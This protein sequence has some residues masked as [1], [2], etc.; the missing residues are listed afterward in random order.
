MMRK[1]NYNSLPRGCRFSTNLTRKM[2]PVSLDDLAV[3]GTRAQRRFA[4]RELRKIEKKTGGK[5][6]D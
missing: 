2:V 3:E 5:H 1:S 4:Q 6:G